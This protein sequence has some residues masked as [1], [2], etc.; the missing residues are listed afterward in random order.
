MRRPVWELPSVSA[1]GLFI[2]E[3]I[4]RRFRRLEELRN[5]RE[6]VGEIPLF[7]APPGRDASVSAM[8]RPDRAPRP[9]TFAS[10]NVALQTHT[11][12][13]SVSDVIDRMALSPDFAAR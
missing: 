8:R 1:R 4:I 11:E 3:V 6:I 9:V 5:S 13:A 7:G 10:T 12:G 2:G